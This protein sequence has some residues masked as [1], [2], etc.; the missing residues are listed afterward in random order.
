MNTQHLRRK[1]DSELLAVVRPCF[2]AA[3]YAGVPDS[4][5]LAVCRLLKER[6]ETPEEFVSSSP[7]FFNDPQDYDE[8]SRRKNWRPDTPE[9]MRQVRAG[10]AALPDFT[11]ASIEA[12]IR[13][14][15]ERNQMGAGRIIHPLRLAVTGRSQGPGLFELMEVVGRDACLR[16]IDRAVD[17]LQV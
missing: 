3:G 16:R 15:A 13:T 14:L 2:D 9:K 4:Y 8:V 1:S 12:V 5:L 17:R 6:V 7:Y 11:H 10:L